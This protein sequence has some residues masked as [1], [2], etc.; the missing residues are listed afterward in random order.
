VGEGAKGAKGLEG[1][2]EMPT[3]ADARAEHALLKQKLVEMEARKSR[4]ATDASRAA[5]A[6][7]PILQ[8]NLDRKCIFPLKHPDVWKMVRPPSLPPSIHP[9]LSLSLAR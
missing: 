5:E 2:R 6:N 3:L 9:S 1:A 4:S 7:E 8:K